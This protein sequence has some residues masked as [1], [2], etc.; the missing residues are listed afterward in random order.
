MIIAC[1]NQTGDDLQDLT[2]NC[3][4]IW[5]RSRAEK[6]PRPNSIRESSPGRSKGRGSQGEILWR[7]GYGESGS[8]KPGSPSSAD[9]FG[10]HQ[11]VPAEKPVDLLLREQTRWLAFSDLFRSRLETGWL[12]LSATISASVAILVRSATAPSGPIRKRTSPRKREQG[13]RRLLREG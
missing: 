8:G 10:S 6:A 9:F 4:F 1:D 12:P 3:R 13:R 2:S 5:K 11:E 7:R